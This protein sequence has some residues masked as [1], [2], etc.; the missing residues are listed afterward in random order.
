MVSVLIKMNKS[1]DAVTSNHDAVAD[2]SSDLLDEKRGTV[3]DTEDMKRMGKQQL[4]RVS[5]PRTIR[6]PDSASLTVYSET[7][8]SSLYLALR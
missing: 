6:P 1:I 8:A 5:R 3:K 2:S 4:F 7:L